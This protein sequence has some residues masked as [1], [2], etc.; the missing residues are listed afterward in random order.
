MEQPSLLPPSLD[1]LIPAQ[2][3]ARVVNRVVDE[4]DIEPLLAKYK[5][6]GTSSYHPRMMLTSDRV[7][8]YPE[9]LFVAEDRKGIMGEHRVYVDISGGNKPDFHT[10]NNFVPKLLTV[11]SNPLLVTDNMRRVITSVDTGPYK[12]V[13]GVIKFP[14]II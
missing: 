1:E 9:D 6:G 13:W 14:S 7:C 12:T 8:L 11:L 2:H 5:G 4:L 3:L 10:I